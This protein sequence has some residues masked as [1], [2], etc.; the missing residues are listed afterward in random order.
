MTRLAIGRES[1]NVIGL[2]LYRIHTPKVYVLVAFGMY[3]ASEALGQL[4][5]QSARQ[6]VLDRSVHMQLIDISNLKQNLTNMLQ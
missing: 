4:C 2:P 3:C 1:V 6:N 5:M